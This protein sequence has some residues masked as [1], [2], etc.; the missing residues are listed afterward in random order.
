MVDRVK[1][2][3]ITLRTRASNLRQ[4]SRRTPVFRGFAAHVVGKAKDEYPQC[5]LSLQSPNASIVH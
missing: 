3:W 2:L 5:Q 1:S 4:R